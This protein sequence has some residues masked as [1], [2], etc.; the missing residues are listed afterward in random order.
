[1]M[2]IK[3]RENAYI[4]IIMKW[5]QTAKNAAHMLNRA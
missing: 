4:I 3:K 1:M 5:S 2:K